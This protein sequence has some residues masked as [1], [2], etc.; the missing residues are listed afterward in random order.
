MI[1]TKDKEYLL[2]IARK[3]D[4]NKNKIK[5]LD[6]RIDN[7]MG[8]INLKIDSQKIEDINNKHNLK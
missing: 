5:D 7:L 3:I 6:K 1:N 4:E 2:S 8:K